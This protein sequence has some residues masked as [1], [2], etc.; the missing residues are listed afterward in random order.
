MY[1]RSL[2]IHEEEL[3]STHPYTATS[4]N[5]LANLYR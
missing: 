3:G 2:E 4:L 1:L 5:N